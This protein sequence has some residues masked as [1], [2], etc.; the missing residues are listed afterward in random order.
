MVPVSPLFDQVLLYFVKNKGDSRA[1][2]HSSIGFNSNRILEESGGQDSYHVFSGD[3]F[4]G[5][6]IAIVSSTGSVIDLSSSGNFLI[7][8]F[9]HGATCEG[10]IKCL[11][12][13]CWGSRDLISR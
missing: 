10:R 8:F 1:N 2:V 12:D 13:L 11:R 7:H 9:F 5:I 6:G 4:V 3:L